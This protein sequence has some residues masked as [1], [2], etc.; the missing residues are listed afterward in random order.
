MNDMTS[1]TSIKRAR[2]A[3]MNFLARREH[4]K[5]ELIEKLTKKDIDLNIAEEAINKLA[6]EDLQSDFRFAECIIRN[7]LKK[8]QGPIAIK[9]RLQ[10]KHIAEHII[11]DLLC[12]LDV[13]WQ[14]QAR[15]TYHK[16]FKQTKERDKK[17]FAKGVRFL[18]YKGFSLEIIM[19]VVN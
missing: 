7:S 9:T 15:N 17:E 2:L 11:E 6:L 19:A 1:I 12:N 16:K 14:Q 18:Q 5:S 4:S 10:Q 13:D 3:A 8:G